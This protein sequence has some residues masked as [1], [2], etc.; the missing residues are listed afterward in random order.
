MFDSFDF[1]DEGR[2]DLGDGHVV[3]GAELRAALPLVELDVGFEDRLFAD[4][5]VPE[6]RGYLSIH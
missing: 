5:A 3:E 6:G 2:F 1:I 4:E